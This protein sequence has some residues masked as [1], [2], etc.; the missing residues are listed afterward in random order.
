MK[1]TIT[2]DGA[3]LHLKETLNGVKIK[4]GQGYSVK[5]TAMK[6]TDTGN[7]YIAKFPSHSSVEQD[8]YICM[9]YSQAYLLLLALQS[10]KGLADDSK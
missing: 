2:S 3:T 1:Q 5:G 4:H 10:Q 8:H 9:D 7:G 6:L